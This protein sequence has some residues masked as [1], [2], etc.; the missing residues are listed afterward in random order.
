MFILKNYKNL[1]IFFFQNSNTPADCSCVPKIETKKRET[2]KNQFDCPGCIW[3]VRLL[4]QNASYVLK[5][6]LKRNPYVNVFKGW[7]YLRAFKWPLFEHDGLGKS[8]TYQLRFKATLSKYMAKVRNI[9]FLSPLVPSKLEKNIQTETTSL[10]QFAYFLSTKPSILKKVFYK[11]KHRWLCAQKIYKLRQTKLSQFVYFS[12]ILRERE[13]TKT[14][15]FC[16]WY[17]FTFASFMFQ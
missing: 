4:G 1:K 3:L 14:K 15:Y 5:V 8:L 12:L 6:T 16:C 13:E 17:Y 2:R 11:S 10:S 7:L 9:W